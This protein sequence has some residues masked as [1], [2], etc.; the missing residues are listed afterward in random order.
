MQLNFLL[1]KTI[2]NGGVPV[3]L[4]GKSEEDWLAEI[5][6]MNNPQ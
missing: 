3:E 6:S 2:K 5:K 4:G 1:L